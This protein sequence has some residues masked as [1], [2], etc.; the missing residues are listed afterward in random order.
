MAYPPQISH[1]TTSIVTTYHHRHTATSHTLP[2]LIKN[3][4]QIHI[5]IN[6]VT[7][8]T[9]QPAP[10]FLSD[11]RLIMEIQFTA[12]HACSQKGVYWNI[13]TT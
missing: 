9:A 7:T 10:A 4:P 5:I 3:N 13:P 8:A 12:T 11:R 6:T 1:F 2:L